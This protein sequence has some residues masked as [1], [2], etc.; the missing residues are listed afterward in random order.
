MIVN[1]KTENKQTN[2]QNETTT[3]KTKRKTKTKQN[4]HQQNKHKLITR[5]KQNTGHIG[6]PTFEF[7]NCFLSGAIFW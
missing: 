1:L 4:I 7:S 3:I 5:G 6:N 2:K